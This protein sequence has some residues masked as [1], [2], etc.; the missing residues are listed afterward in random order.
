MTMQ[1]IIMEV[2]INRW[3]GR[4]CML[5]RR[6]KTTTTRARTVAK[7]GKSGNKSKGNPNKCP[8]CGKFMGSGSHG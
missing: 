1:Y 2:V 3:Q 7:V 5:L 4:E 8:V 6:K